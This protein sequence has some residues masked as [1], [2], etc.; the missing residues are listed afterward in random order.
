VSAFSLAAGVFRPFGQLFDF[1][2][3]T[4]RR[5]HWP[6]MVLLVGLWLGGFYALLALTHPNASF[7]AYM[8]AVVEFPPPMKMPFLDGLYLLLT[9]LAFA[10]VTRRLH[11]VGISGSWMAAYLS[12]EASY[13]A[14]VYLGLDMTLWYPDPSTRPPHIPIV[15][16][17]LAMALPLFMRVWFLLLAAFCLLPGTAGP[18]LYGPDPR[19]EVVS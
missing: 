18:N 2:G 10:A 5:D 13:I 7:A 6:Y 15:I 4:R 17:T 8:I 19:T 16:F 14:L 3:R 9:L 1:G 11:D 12:L